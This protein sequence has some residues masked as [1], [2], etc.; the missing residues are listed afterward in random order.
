MK[1]AQKLNEQTQVSLKLIL[2]FHILH[3]T[4]QL[5]IN[6]MS[7]SSSDIFKY[8]KK[9]ENININ[10]LWMEDKLLELH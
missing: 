8:Q 1:N 6:S 9:N 3:N 5:I 7:N 2:K 10:V 4:I